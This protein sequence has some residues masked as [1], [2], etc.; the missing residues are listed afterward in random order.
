MDAKLR[1]EFLRERLETR[2]AYN[3]HLNPKRRTIWRSWRCMLPLKSEA[4]EKKEVEAFL[5]QGA[6]MAKQEKDDRVVWIQGR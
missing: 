3:R 1:G 4:V 6:E 2:E 5:K